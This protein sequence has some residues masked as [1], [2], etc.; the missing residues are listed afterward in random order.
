MLNVHR[1][2]PLLP[3]LAGAVLGLGLCTRPVRPWA[4][5]DGILFLLLLPSAFP[6]LTISVSGVG[7]LGWLALNTPAP[8]SGICALLCDVFLGRIFLAVL[9][10]RSADKAA[11]CASQIVLAE[12]PKNT[13]RHSKKQC[14][15]QSCGAHCFL[16]FTS[17][18]LPGPDGSSPRRTPNPPGCGRRRLGRGYGPCPWAPRGR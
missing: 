16:A 18:V 7:G 9:P 8:M 2:F 17:P 1:F 14:A 13:D 11:P 10:Q 12:S 6:A 3:V 15:P 5:V 4:V